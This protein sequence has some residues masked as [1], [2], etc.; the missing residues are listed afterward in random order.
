MGSFVI[1][2]LRETITKFLRIGLNL[3]FKEIEVIGLE[4]IPPDKPLIVCLNHHNGLMDPL[5]ILT[6]GPKKICFLAKSTLFSIP[7]VGA[8]TKALD[9]IPVFRMQDDTGPDMRE[10]NLETFRKAAQIL[11]EG[12]VLALFP[13]GV[14]HSDPGLKPLKTGAARIAL[15]A[16]IPDLL[17]VPVALVY[18]AK[19]M[20]RSRVTIVCGKPFGISPSGAADPESERKQIRTV[21][22]AIAR[23]LGPLLDESTRLYASRT[24]DKE[25]QNIALRAMIWALFPL[26][27]IGA[28]L[29]YIPYKLT[30]WIAHSLSK[31]EHDL[32]STF[33]FMAAFLVFPIYWLALGAVIGYC[34]S[35]QL[36]IVALVVQPLLGLFTL[37]ATEYL[38][39]FG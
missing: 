18:S 31:S 7:V 33:K 10:K 12:A 1:Q 39:N 2:G 8:V 14:S 4:Q 21:T 5:L 24:K 17:I 27:G 29:H 34:L 11:R 23:N 9:C 16:G 37:W 6:Q 19:W 13:E 26:W 25:D 38:F 15:G 28:L 20:F 22:D 36:I 35:V 30:G 32:V 3:F